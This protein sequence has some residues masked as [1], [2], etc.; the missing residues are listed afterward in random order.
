MSDEPFASPPDETFVSHVDE[1]A[2]ANAV[3]LCFFSH[4]DADGRIE[5]YVLHYLRELRAAGFVVVF[6]T[7][8][9]LVT[10]EV[11]RT[12]GL[13]AAVIERENIG[14]DFGGWIECLV[15]F[16]H[17]RAELLL[18]CNDSVY[19]PFWSLADFIADLTS[20]PADFHGAVLNLDPV[21]HL[22]SWF[23]LLRPSAYR[24]S[25][26]R[27]LMGRPP[28]VDMSKIEIITRYEF[29]LTMMLV[30][31]G[32]EYRAGFDP[33]DMGPVLAENPLDPTHVLWRELLTERL[34]P[35][36]KIGVLRERPST[37]RGLGNWRAVLDAFDP[38]L[39]NFAARNLERRLARRVPPRG[40]VLRQ[41]VD[42]PTRPLAHLPV[43]H[44]VLARE[45]RERAAV[46]R[47]AGWRRN[48]W[49]DASR[50]VYDVIRAPY[51]WAYRAVDRVRRRS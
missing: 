29:A 33:A 11:G 15:R 1:D 31:E 26:F 25:A 45:V 17:I 19:G 20:A 46:G 3:R 16:P 5:D 50:A 6:V 44:A 24:S 21:P 9:T 27:D 43:A 23:L 22:Q 49:Y 39:A 35:F 28:P 47:T 38:V 18:L 40:G 37:V 41:L 36:V 12:R 8:A 2:I 48:R 14:L 42:W 30:D 4:F 10:G 7:T 13:C 51:V 32:C 34:V